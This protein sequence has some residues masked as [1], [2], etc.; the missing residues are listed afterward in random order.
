M[1]GDNK[2][3]TQRIAS[4]IN[5][6]NSNHTNLTNYNKNSIRN[7][8]FEE[9]TPKDNYSESNSLNKYLKNK[10]NSNSNSGTESDTNYYYLNLRKNISLGKNNSGSTKTINNNLECFDP[11]SNESQNLF[12]NS[13]NKYN[14]QDEVSN[15][16]NSNHK[17]QLN[18]FEKNNSEIF[19]TLNNNFVGDNSFSNSSK[20]PLTNSS[21]KFNF[22]DDNLYDNSC[23]TFS[24]N[25][26]HFNNS[27]YKKDS[28]NLNHIFVSNLNKQRY[29]RD[30]DLVIA[31]DKKS[32]IGEKYTIEIKSPIL[33]SLEKIYAIKLTE[34]KRFF[35][36]NTEKNHK[37]VLLFVDKKEKINK[38]ILQIPQFFIKFNICLKIDNNYTLKLNEKMNLF[39]SSGTR[40][41]NHFKIIE[42]NEHNLIFITHD[43]NVN[44]Y[45][46]SNSFT[47]KNDQILFIKYD[48][49][50][51]RLEFITIELSKFEE[52]LKKL[53]YKFEYCY[54]KY[55]TKF[56][57]MSNTPN[58]NSMSV[59][60]D[61]NDKSR[62]SNIVIN[63]N[64]RLLLFKKEDSYNSWQLLT[65]D[66]SDPHKNNNNFCRFC[67]RKSSSENFLLDCQHHICSEC[68][69]IKLKCFYCNEKILRKKFN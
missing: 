50:L 66:F 67:R 3:E 40:L 24:N 7:Q 57:L 6:D 34:D 12:S 51:C 61:L 33:Y 15:R 63:H 68:I 30:S 10:L 44:N 56:K 45:T 11:F 18:S 47:I 17:I 39:F 58:I 42:I 46:Y 49:N 25:K 54:I 60:L 69:K 20:N 16:T 62:D 31:E 4:R 19:K 1:E 37:D 29:F 13:S 21:H 8:T 22:P 5:S 23:R 53:I 41:L 38:L 65:F 59:Y 55:D 43:I 26:I 64:F 9:Y 2:Q 28:E 36:E 27:V 14:F 52:T 32:F 35:I 48:N